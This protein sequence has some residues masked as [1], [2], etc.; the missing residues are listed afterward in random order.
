[1]PVRRQGLRGG[2][3]QG[4]QG[5]QQ[6]LA[7]LLQNRLV[8]GRQKEAIGLQNEA[9]TGRQNAAYQQ[10]LAA[11]GI[12]PDTSLEDVARI[13][14]QRQAQAQQQAL[15]TQMGDLASGGLDE[16]RSR[17]NVGDPAARA[18]YMRNT[19]PERTT[20]MDEKGYTVSEKQSAPN[21]I[22]EQ[23][24]SP[25]TQAG[26]TAYATTTGQ[27]TAQREQG[28]G[29]FE[30]PQQTPFS[31]VPGGAEGLDR[32]QALQK[33]VMGSDAFSDF[34]NT[35]T[36]AVEAQ[37][38]HDR[39]NELQQRGQTQ[40]VAQYDNQLATL[41]ARSLETGRLTDQDIERVRPVEGQGRAFK[42]R[43]LGAYERAI[44][45]A[46]LLPEERDV[47]R[48]IAVTRWQD[49]A[50]PILEAQ[51]GF[52]L[53]PLSAEG[54]GVDPAFIQYAQRALSLDPFIQMAQSRAR[55]SLQQQ[56]AEQGA[57]DIYQMLLNRR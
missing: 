24:V 28:I 27:A 15:A 29:P 23:F 39:A 6:I 56:A 26:R 52:Q 41:I 31:N 20:G 54:A 12:G 32:I 17:M 5:L 45:G 16:A 19:T 53:G 3:N 18:Y 44:N 25:E 2:A 21:F 22:G 14:Q 35:L 38:L 43:I 34:Q 37:M 8:S 57:G 50:R 30:Q 47:L 1:M 10:Q 48:D 13:M 7:M 51:I 11:S 40:G 42:D 49:R 4:L 36:S 55:S 9:V 33:E 46:M